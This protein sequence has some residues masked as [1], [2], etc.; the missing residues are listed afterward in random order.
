L[1]GIVTQ[2]EFAE[3]IKKL[4]RT[5][6]TYKARIAILFVY[7][8]VLAIA[9]IMIQT[10]KRWIINAGITLLFVALVVFFLIIFG[11]QYREGKRMR[12][13]VAE[14]SKKYSTRSPIPCS[15]R[16]ETTWFYEICGNNQNRPTYRVSITL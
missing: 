12:E 4:N 6:F 15:W 11:M 1:N 10:S 9:I 8:F 16:L 2:D 14:E 13:I 5:I 3:A 7:V